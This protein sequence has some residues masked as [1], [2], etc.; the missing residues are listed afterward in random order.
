MIHWV[1][2][3]EKTIPGEHSS[4]YVTI[5]EGASVIELFCQG[6]SFNPLKAIAILQ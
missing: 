6:S 1:W 5:I 2:G 3:K 4:G